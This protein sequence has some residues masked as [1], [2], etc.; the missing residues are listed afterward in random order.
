MARTKKATNSAITNTVTAAPGTLS[1][2]TA[3][4]TAYVVSNGTTTGNT[5]L[6]Y[7]PNS[8]ATWIAPNTQ[9]YPGN[10]Q[11]VNLPTTTT[12]IP[13]TF[14]ITGTQWPSP[15]FIL[16]STGQFVVSIADCALFL[17][18]AAVKLKDNTYALDIPLYYKYHSVYIEQDFSEIDLNETS[19]SKIYKANKRLAIFALDKINKRLEFSSVC[20]DT[21]PKANLDKLVDESFS[22]VTD[23][24]EY[25]NTL[26]A[27]VLPIVGYK[28]S[29]FSANKSGN[30]MSS[31]LTFER[32]LSAG[33]TPVM[34]LS[35]VVFGGLLTPTKQDVLSTFDNLATEVIVLDKAAFPKVAKY[36][37]PEY[38]YLTLRDDL[39]F[40]A[41]VRSH[42][43]Y[44][45]E[46]LIALLEKV[47]LPGGRVKEFA[48]C[49][50]EHIGL[51][52]R[53]KEPSDT[54]VSDIKRFLEAL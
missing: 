44:S 16:T 9:M 4:N 24:T 53:V 23:K 32:E 40:T 42:T 46:G 47:T 6:Q 39:D 25:L 38:S 43:D 3:N 29:N 22:V 49:L 50:E 41:E 36:F 7:S 21:D 20:P 45:S 27:R 51:D 17:N 35:H 28:L 12:T 2:N 5:V 34:H 52:H 15:E 37:S 13:S 11:W 8:G 14:T 31:S 54:A 30:V 18:N 1:F 19:S 26:Y 48:Q 10:Q 33:I